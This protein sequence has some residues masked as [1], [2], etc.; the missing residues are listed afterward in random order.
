MAL[1]NYKVDELIQITYQTF[2]A[3]SGQIVTM[4]IFDETGSK[5]LVNFPDVTMTEIGSTGRYT[6][7]F[8][9]DTEG[10]WVVM[11][12]YGTPTRGKIV[13]QYSVGGYNLDEIGQTIDTIEIQTQ[14][15][16]S[17]PMVG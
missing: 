16:D 10:E 15:I 11:I 6:G 8:T 9:P 12:S 7:S 14:G 13:K 5:D 1:K 3:Q 4:E 2:A 17:P